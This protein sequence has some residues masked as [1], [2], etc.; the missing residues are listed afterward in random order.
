ML[1][2]AVPTGLSP[3]ERDRLIVKVTFLM[4]QNVNVVKKANSEGYTANSDYANWVE[5]GMDSIVLYVTEATISMIE[6]QFTGKAFVVKE[7]GVIAVLKA[8]QT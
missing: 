1:V 6:K 8:N 7:E 4:G 5:A 3:I 2:I